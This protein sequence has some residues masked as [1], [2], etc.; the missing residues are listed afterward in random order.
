M[1]NATDIQ[2]I[3]KPIGKRVKFK[4]P[5]NEGDK[6]GTLLDR[7]IIHSEPNN[8]VPYWDVV[9]LIEFPEEKEKQW[10]RISYYRKPK[11]KLNF[12]GQTSITEP[13]SVW[14]KLLSQAAREKP[15]FRKIILDVKLELKDEK[16]K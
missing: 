6:S 15:W 8:Q 7:C 1:Y 3:L 9:D 12:A 2:K 13:V 14:K 10:I 16:G 4:Y 5:N 11:G